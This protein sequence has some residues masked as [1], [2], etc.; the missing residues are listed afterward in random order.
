MKHSPALVA[1]VDDDASVC[2]AL[3]RLVRSLGM[4]A[5]TFPS[6]ESFFHSIPSAERPDCIVLDVQMP[7]MNGLEM[8]QRMVQEH[9]H[10]PLI[11]MTA[12]SDEVVAKRVAAAGA[13]G[14]LHKPFSDRSLIELLERALHV[15]G[16]NNSGSNGDVR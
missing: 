6:G 16:A 5:V 4:R 12:H 9:L 13:V 7:G 15:A 8:Q 1:I 3:M 11:F 10:I 14:F 2:R